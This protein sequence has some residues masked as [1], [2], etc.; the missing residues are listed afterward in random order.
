MLEPART[1][2]LYRSLWRGLARLP[3]LHRSDRLNL[4]RLYR[5]QLRAALV[6]GQRDKQ[7]LQ[8]QIDRTLSLLASSPRLALNLSSLTY[9]HTPNFIRGA[10]NSARLAHLPKPIVWDPKDP[11]AARRAWDKREKDQLRDP[12]W[13]ISQS[14]DT[15]LRRMW[16]E[17]EGGKHG[18][19]LGRIERAR[20]R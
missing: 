15:G 5:P 12:V 4:Q 6:D 19:W 14:V 7:D 3:R 9:H 13:R 11:T 2:S 8:E 10:A 16:R 20:Y 18:A 1:R 17:A